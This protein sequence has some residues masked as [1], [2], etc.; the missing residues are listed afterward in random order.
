MKEMAVSIALLHG[1]GRGARSFDRVSALLKENGYEISTLELPGFGA[2]PPPPQAWS[3]DDYVE[4][5]RA[6]I[7]EKGIRRC[8]LFGHSFGGRVAIKL[9]ARY[10]EMLAGLILCDAAGVTP[11]PKIKIAVFGFFSH[12]GRAIFSLPLLSLLRKPVRRII[13]FLSQERDYYSLQSDVMRDTFTK[14]I[15]ENL[16]SYLAD[17]RVPTLV[18]W[19]ERDRMTPVADAHRIVRGVP[20]SRLVILRGIGHSPHIE[21][22]QELTRLVGEFIA[23]THVE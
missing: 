23:H 16:E 9:A 22:P 10:P 6:S 14:V 18:I 11:R 7:I 15:A 8:Y 19:G 1:W 17:I 2:T 13:Y 3:V 5:V 21:A 12:I 20:G 4:H